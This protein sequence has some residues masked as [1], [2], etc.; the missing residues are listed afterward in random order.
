MTEPPTF[1]V[2]RRPRLRQTAPA[3]LKITSFDGRR[4]SRLQHWNRRRPRGARARA[5][6]VQ[7]TVG[8]RLGELQKREREVGAAESALGD[9]I[10]R[11][12]LTRELFP[13]GNFQR[14]RA[15]LHPDKPDR[16][17]EALDAAHSIFTTLFEVQEVRGKQFV[18]RKWTPNR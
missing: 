15:C 10:E 4:C 13:V 5:R 9:R 18:R 3:P 7:E 12:A 16:S 8:A 17:K 11:M 1:D 6:G 14:I 2:V